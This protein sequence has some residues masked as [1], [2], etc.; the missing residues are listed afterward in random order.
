MQNDK[1]ESPLDVPMIDANAPYSSREEQI[2]EH[3]RPFIVVAGRKY[4]LAD[5]EEAPNLDDLP[6]DPRLASVASV[7]R[8][9]S[10]F[11]RA[12]ILL[13]STSASAFGWLWLCATMLFALVL[14][15][16]FNPL[17]SSYEKRA[18][19]EEFAKARVVSCEDADYTINGYTPIV[20][21]FEGVAPDGSKFSGKSYSTSRVSVDAEI[22]VEK[23]RGTTDVLRACGGTLT[24]IKKQNGLILFAAIIFLFVGIGVALGIVSP[25]LTGRRF[26]KL[27]VNGE[28]ALGV[29]V[30]VADSGASINGVPEKIVT[31]RFR[32]SDGLDYEARAKTMQA[33]KLTDSPAKIL[34][35]ASENPK[36]SVLLDALPKGVKTQ[37]NGRFVASF[38]ST[39]APLCFVV[40]FLCEIA[41]TCYFGTK[42]E[43]ATFSVDA[44]PAAVAEESAETQE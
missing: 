34:F 43:R 21:R 16:S 12:L 9:V 37:E 17:V 24:P 1:I 25:V 14:F 32:A 10:F 40:V 2:D 4:V 27:L 13:R 44:Q 39:L 6:E 33:S 35:Y 31:F 19:W 20:W 3:G 11:A 42:F 26:L 36:N 23:A 41:A 29:P 18:D 7:P 8:E 30:D 15:G 28:S 38:F 22:V 5:D